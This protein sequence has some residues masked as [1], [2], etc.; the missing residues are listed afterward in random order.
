MNAWADRLPALEAMA[1]CQLFFVG[2]APRSGTTWVQLLLD[3]HPEISCRGE[4]LFPQALAAPLD[5]LAAQWA[6]AVAEKNATVFRDI[7]GYPA[8]P[9]GLA[10]L[11]LGTAVLAALAAQAA[12]K[13]PRAV[14]EKTP[15][16]VFLFPRLARLFPGA[17]FIG[18][19][20]DPRDVL[21]SAWRFFPRQ[22]GES[23]EAFVARA[24]PSLDQGARAMLAL[25][26]S[27][28]GCVV[29][30]EQLSADPEAA[31]AGLC[32]YLGVADDAAVVGACV[33]QC[34]FEA[35]AGRP[36]SAAA[37]E[38]VFLGG[39]VV[40][41]WRRT[42]SGASAERIVAALGWSFPAFGW[43]V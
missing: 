7:G 37:G 39:G 12:G 43:A 42:L 20:R 33:G 21:A 1:R 18:V 34:R 2:G 29:T 13:H 31:F 32:R 38:R 15:E 19:A 35:L 17:R 24:L 16:N 23:Q 6:R 5:L 27:G 10:D 3:A 11:L 14:G 40:G 36:A 41:G 25:K 30:Y 4:A 9:E 26:E 28:A 8:L 22:A